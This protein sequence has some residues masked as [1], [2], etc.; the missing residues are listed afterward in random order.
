MNT[1]LI[2]IIT[3]FLITGL[4]FTLGCKKKDKPDKT[5]AF[6]KY[7]GGLK[8]HNATDVI[9]TADGGYILAGTSIAGSD[10]G[11]ILVIKTDAEGNEIWN[12]SIG[13]ATTYDECGSIAIMPD[14]GYIVLGTSAMKPDRVW[15]IN[16]LEPTKDSTAM[17]A[18][19]LTSLGAVMWSTTYASPSLA[20]V[21]IGTFGKSVVVNPNN[22]C[23]LAGMLDS[24]GV[25]SS[26]LNIYAFLIDGNGVL[27]QRSASN[28]IP[29]TGGAEGG[30]DDF[31]VD[32]I[33]AYGSGLEHEYIISTS[34]TIS[35]ENTPRLVPLRLSGNA[36]LQNQGVT[37]TDWLELT[38]NNGQQISRLSGDNYLLV[39][40]KGTSSSSDIYTI[41]LSNSGGLS[42]IQSF[43]YGDISSG[44]IDIG[45]SAIP[46]ADGGYVILGITNSVAYTK[47]AAKLRDVL[48]IKVNSSGSVEWEKVFGGRGDD[49]ASRV[50]Q[51]L[52]N[53]YLI[54]GTIAFGDDVS[55]S[56]NSNAISLIKL[57]ANGELSNLE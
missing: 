17:F 45:V 55:N 6:V 22:E 25:S 32:A 24:S 27:L 5:K 30:N 35:G 46:T 38:Y 18:A 53:G 31:V 10:P 1:T 51:T 41:K 39:G 47:D 19:R 26:S 43:T 49:F 52:D 56:G 28:T 11:N 3:I 2:R 20:Y 7:F 40:S 57:N 12:Q 48:L 21:K 54:C 8:G 34:T 42:K 13:K 36:L 44:A 15:D 23:L 33:R 14:G 4:L 29:Y 9:Q 50:I 16:A 37:K